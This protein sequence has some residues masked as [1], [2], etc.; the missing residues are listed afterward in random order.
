MQIVRSVQE[1]QGI[2]ERLRSEGKRIG[3]IPTM[4]SLHQGHLSLIEL[5]H[6]ESDVVVTTLFVNPTQFGEGED[7][8]RYPRDLDRDKVLAQGAGTDILFVPDANEMYPEGYGTFVSVEGVT[9]I[10]EGA[11]RP[12][13]FRGVATIVLKLFNITKP[14]V[15][16]FGQK[17][18]QQLFII[19]K[20]V[21]DLNLDVQIRVAPILRDV[22]G[23]AL[24][25]R[26]VYLKSDERLRATALSRSLKHAEAR[27]RAGE[28]S[29]VRVKG[30][31]QEI[32]RQA[33]PMKIDYLTFVD[34]S[35]FREV[36]AIEPPSLLIA[37]AVRLGATRL[38]DNILIPVP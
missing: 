7:F 35:S 25:S 14:H 8:E 10:L 9:E 18:A 13:H 15:A 12:G 27:V 31:M 38:I 24:S 20:L 6:R 19:Q 17:D 22:D 29:V 34:P 26:N 36:A 37:L 3:V 4:G 30:E 32:L 16:V 21:G 33:D 11:F 2:A 1:M 23:L 5:A 28:R